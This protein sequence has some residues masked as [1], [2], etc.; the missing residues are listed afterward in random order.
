MCTRS[1]RSTRADQL[2]A[3]RRS[4]GSPTT[5]FRPGEYQI[6]RNAPSSA[7][8]MAAR[9]DPNYK[10]PRIEREVRTFNTQ[11]ELDA[12]RGARRSNSPLTGYENNWRRV[13]GQ[14]PSTQT[15]YRQDRVAIKDESSARRRTRGIRANE[16]S[17]T[18]SGT[19]QRNRRGG[20]RI[21]RVGAQTA[22][23]SS[24]V[25]IPT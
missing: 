14:G 20:L 6:T 9:F 2:S 7:N 10:M 13:D 22:G 25:N 16:S 23:G 12:A 24:G 4:V 21:D 17:L 1:G 8:L 11:A 5:V 19:Q 3:E 15:A 18:A